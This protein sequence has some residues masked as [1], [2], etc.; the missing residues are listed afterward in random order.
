MPLSLYMYYSQVTQ[1]VNKLN[2]YSL[3]CYNGVIKYY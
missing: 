2:Y 3:Q 1:L